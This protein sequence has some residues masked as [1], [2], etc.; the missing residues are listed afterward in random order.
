MAEI[1][2]VAL[3]QHSPSQLPLGSGPAKIRERIQHSALK[4]G[5]GV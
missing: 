5:M 4:V 2:T 1:G 3:V